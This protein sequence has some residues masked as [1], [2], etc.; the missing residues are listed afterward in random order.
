MLQFLILFQYLQSSVKFKT[1]S[2]VTVSLLQDRFSFLSWTFLS[3][4]LGNDQT[5][6]IEEVTARIYKLLA[7]TP[8]NGAEFSESVK[9]ILHR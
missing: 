4:V 1:E 6:W 5:K 8:P 3:Q 7:E 9:H 2:Q